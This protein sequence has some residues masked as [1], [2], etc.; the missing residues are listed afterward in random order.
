MKF[1]EVK[2]VNKT[3]STGVTALADL[4]V[5]I[6]RRDGVT[7]QSKFIGVINSRGLL[8]EIV[9]DEDKDKYVVAE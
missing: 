6:D 9:Y 4:S 8:K 3:Y 2:N 7:C 1:I 5:E